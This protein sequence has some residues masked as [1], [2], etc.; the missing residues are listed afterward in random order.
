M[1]AVRVLTILCAGV[2]MASEVGKVWPAERRTWKDPEF[3]QEITQWTQHASGSHHLYFNIETFLDSDHA[4]IVSNR[5][6]QPNYY[7][8]NLNSGEMTQMTSEAGVSGSR[9][10][11]WPQRKTLWYLVGS[12]FKEMNT[13]T[14]ATRTIRTLEGLRPQAFTVTCDGRF[15]VF[16]VNKAEGGAKP[17]RLSTGPFAIYRLPIAGG[18]P[19]QISPDLGF[20]IGHLQA[21]PTDPTRISYC[22]QHLLD[23]GRPGFAGNTPQ[24]TWWIKIDGSEGGPLSV[25]DIGLH[26][27]HE[28]WFPDGSRMGYSARYL[29]GP[30]KGQAFLGS[31]AADG[32]DNYMM[33]APIGAAHTRMFRDLRH[34]VTDLWDGSVLALVTLEGRRI[35]KV[36]KLF[37]HDSSW[38][39]QP[40]HPHPQFHPEGRMVMF[41]TD[42]SGVP[43][44]YSVKLNLP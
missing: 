27:T 23:S 30:K 19:V 40:S 29:W 17:G 41:S 9:I 16:A 37:R 11:H 6:G 31:F 38:K 21:S 18:E 43:Q 3:G 44:V 35:G 26:R 15:L 20:M 28:F 2:C 22:W 14:L 25:Q 10:W 34:W 5:S 12:T 7:R 8:L 42:K 4:I 1:A 13:Q 32:S 36:E 24:R 39:G 33:P